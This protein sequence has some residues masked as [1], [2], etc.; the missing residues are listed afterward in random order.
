[1]T[2]VDQLGVHSAIHLFRVTTEQR[3]KNDNKAQ[4]LA[5]GD[6]MKPAQILALLPLRSS[7]KAAIHHHFIIVTLCPQSLAPF[8]SSVF[9]NASLTLSASSIC[10]SCIAGK[11]VELDSKPA[12]LML[13]G[14]GTYILS[15]PQGKQ[16]KIMAWPSPPFWRFS[17]FELLLAVSIKV[18]IQLRTGD[19]MKRTHRLSESLTI[20]HECSKHPSACGVPHT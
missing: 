19:R 6:C 15:S 7:R 18:Q 17:S 3:K 11:T 13:A 14:G 12:L 20:Y 5:R 8:C 2:T 4:S 16:R 9:K 1:M 10:A